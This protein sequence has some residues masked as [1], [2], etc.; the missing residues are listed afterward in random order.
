VLSELTLMRTQNLENKSAD[1]KE[2]SSLKTNSTEFKR[3]NKN[4]QFLKTNDS[5]VII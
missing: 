3:K 1:L 2:V 4:K 5:Y